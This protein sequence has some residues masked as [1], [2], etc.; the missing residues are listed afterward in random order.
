M[1]VDDIACAVLVTN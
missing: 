1:H